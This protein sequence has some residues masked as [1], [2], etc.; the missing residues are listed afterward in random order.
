MTTAGPLSTSLPHLA[1]GL[2]LAPMEGVTSFA[3]RVWF[4]LAS[5]PDTMGTPF[6]R[7]T[8]TFPLKTL[9]PTFVPELTTLSGAVPYQIVP[10]LMATEV[11]D[12]LRT[13]RY[14]PNHTS[15]LEL[16]CGCPA[17]TCV[18]KGAGSSLLKDPRVFGEMIHKLA[19]S[20]GPERF[21]VKMR[22][23]YHAA[24]EF[25]S[26]LH[27]ISS[28]P[29]A[30]LTIHGRSRPDRYKGRARW[31]LIQAAT[32]AVNAPVVASG[33][34][35]DRLSFQELMATAP[36]IRGA[37]IGRGA[38]RN[39]WVFNE[40]REGQA[41]SI[42]RETLVHALGCYAL[43]HELDVT[44]PE[45]LHRCARALFA[46]APCGTSEARWQKVFT[47]LAH[48]LTEGHTLGLGPEGEWPAIEL[49]RNTIGR[50]KMLWNYM[51]SSL[52]EHLFHP[53]ILRAKT[54]SDLLI[55]IHRVA[56]PAGDT[57]L[58]LQH[59]PEVDWLYAGGKNPE[60]SPVSSEEETSEEV[61]ES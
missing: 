24:A 42:S 61:G 34:I 43:L 54:L 18:G 6:L 27:A 36:H 49:V 10:Q 57:G 15:F 44:A 59:R 23:G 28:V 19:C 58:L 52:P 29:L 26:L 21:A 22:T 20:L 46:D 3:M 38:L 48:T 60:Q 30:R 13:S 37:L 50:A 55:G 45:R 4:Y 17:P 53:Q 25:P 8:D 33:D 9:P 2:G 39:P 7:V 5:A 56:G 47:T 35:M 31:D 41:I 12:F 14:F 32:G 16:N 51:R 11:D 40:I 1:L